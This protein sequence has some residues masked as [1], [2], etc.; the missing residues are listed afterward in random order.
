[1]ASPAT[2]VVI[3]Q[4]PCGMAL[5]AGQA[6]AAFAAA[7]HPGHVGGGPGL[8][9]EDEPAGSSPPLAVARLLARGGHVGA[10]LFGG[11]PGFF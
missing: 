4:W 9:E 8:V 7:S 3:F 6:G 2:K 5:A 10:R 11:V 1:M